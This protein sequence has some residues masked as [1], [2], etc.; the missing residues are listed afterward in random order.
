MVWLFVPYATIGFACNAP[1]FLKKFKNLDYS[2]GIYI[3]AF[4][5]QQLISMYGQRHGWSFTLILLDSLTLT[6]V[7]A[8]LLW[9]WIEK[10]AL[11]FKPMVHGRSKAV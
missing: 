10:P 2:Y 7:S 4:P 1:E 3:Y 9:H 6:V 5:L 11:R 8:A